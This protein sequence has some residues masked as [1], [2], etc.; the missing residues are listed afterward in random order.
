[1]DNYEKY[2]NSK[3]IKSAEAEMKKCKHPYVGTEHLLLALLKLGEISNICNKYDLTYDNFKKSLLSVVGKSS[4]ETNFILHTPLL[5]MVLLD[6]VEDNEGVLDSK[7]LMISILENGDG[8][9]VRILLNMGIKLDKIYNELKKENN[10]KIDFGVNL[11][12]SVDL[13]E[14]VS[15]RDK[16][17]E[18][19]IETLLRKNKSNPILVGPA[20]VGKTA[21][22]Y[23]LAR[24]IKKGLVPDRLKNKQIISIEMCDL[25]A[26]TKYRG[27]FEEKIKNILDLCKENKD[28]ILFIDEVH[29]IVHA[30]GSEGAIDAANI[31]KPYL[32]N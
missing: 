16:E 19:I 1:M 5:K 9:A 25:V 8:I 11:N 3:I 24:R 13:N 32:S 18:L 4:M 22:V 2:R 31:L 10:L 26:G 27:E 21:I 7:A 29:T 17:L 6:A 30:G 14:V 23:E 28:I 15:G 20:G 12:E